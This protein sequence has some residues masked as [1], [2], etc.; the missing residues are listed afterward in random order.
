MALDKFFNHLVNVQFMLQLRVKYL[1][2]ESEIG[3]MMINGR[4]IGFGNKT[5][6]TALAAVTMALAGCGSDGPYGG[7][8][9]KWYQHHIKEAQ[10]EMK[11]CGGQSVS[12]QMHS[13][14]CERAKMGLVQAMESDPAK[15]GEILGSFLQ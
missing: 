7:H 4:R 5:L 12:K 2:L 8:D 6:W 14:S 9:E 1:A 10:K 13:K 11:W 3:R 15:A